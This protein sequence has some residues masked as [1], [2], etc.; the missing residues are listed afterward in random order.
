VVNVVGLPDDA[1]VVTTRIVPGTRTP[2]EASS[3]SADPDPLPDSTRLKSF[4]LRIGVLPAVGGCKAAVRTFGAPLAP[5]ANAVGFSNAA[6]ALALVHGSP[7][8]RLDVL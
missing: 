8:S 3:I 6:R 2:T 4:N 7:G 1:I 5:S